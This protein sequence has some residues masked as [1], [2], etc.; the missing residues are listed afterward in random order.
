MSVFISYSH[1]DREFADELGQAFIAANVKVWRD[2]YRIREG[3]RLDE[4]I[5][6]AIRSV[7]L[8][9]VLLSASSAASRWVES[10]TAFALEREALGLVEIVP[11][12]LDES[13]APPSLGERLVM[14]GRIGARAVAERL[15]QRALDAA[16]PPSAG[17]RVSDDAR[18]FTHHSRE[19]G[20]DD[21]GRMFVQLDIVSFDLDEPYSILTQFSFVSA[22]PLDD[23]DE[24]SARSRADRLLAACASSFAAEPCRVRLRRG[25]AVR[26]TFSVTDGP[27]RFD[28]A[29]RSL[30]IGKVDRGTVLFNLGALFELIAPD[31]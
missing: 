30:R 6:T 21:T 16:S 28:V 8:F 7:K 14:D 2:A 12:R 15:A 10:E 22:E 4:R 19:T 17:E 24:A 23:R 20:F 5:F 25:E 31:T 1:A 13:S 18:S 9:V 11:V 3:D 27:I 29:C 26:S